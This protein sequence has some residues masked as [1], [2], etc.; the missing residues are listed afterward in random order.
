MKPSSLSLLKF[1][2]TRDSPLLRIRTMTIT[3]NPPQVRDD[4]LCSDQQQQS[5]AQIEKPPEAAA[6]ASLGAPGRVL[7]IDTRVEQAWAHWKKLGRPKYIVAPMVDNS[8]LPFR[9]LCQKYGAQAA[10]T[11]MLHSR[12]FTETD[13][14]NKEFTTCEV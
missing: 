9:L 14:R 8:E 6:P 2:R 4:L 11:P 10:Y 5:D 7:S 12:I 3:S 1:L 13:N